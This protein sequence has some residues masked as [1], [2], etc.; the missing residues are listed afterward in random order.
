MGEGTPSPAK[1]VRRG[2]SLALFDTPCSSPHLDIAVE[3]LHHQ[4]QQ[5]QQQLFLAANQ[6][7]APLH[8]DG[9]TL[10]DFT[11][12]PPPSPNP[13]DVIGSF[14]QQHLALSATT[15]LTTSNVAGAGAAG[16]DGDGGTSAT[17]PAVLLIPTT[18]QGAPG[19]MNT[20]SG[21]VPIFSSRASMLTGTNAVGMTQQHQALLPIDTSPGGITANNNTAAID[22]MNP[23]YVE[24][25]AAHLMPL[26]SDIAAAVAAA[27]AAAATEPG[28]ILGDAQQHNCNGNDNS[29]QGLENNS[30]GIQIQPPARQDTGS[31]L[32]LEHIFDYGDALPHPQANAPGV[33]LPMLM[34]T[35]SNANVLRR[36]PSA[37]WGAFESITLAGGDKGEE[38]AKGKE[39]GGD[40]GRR[41]SNGSSFSNGRS[42]APSPPPEMLS[43]YSSPQA[44]FAAEEAKGG[45]EQGGGGGGSGGEEQQPSPAAVDV[46]PPATSPSSA[47]APGATAPRNASAESTSQAG[48]K[49]EHQQ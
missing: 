19:T 44:A 2:G 32:D 28:I 12:S 45:N 5:L 14:L 47:A 8:V 48:A 43:G 27:A 15:P 6:V 38:E 31:S 3:E 35:V 16:G 37:E 23:S 18:I 40:S 26:P 4:Q 41:P 34:S 33:M 39:E 29:Q 17:I 30:D 49:S 42:K 22:I 1:H 46:A 24:A 20:I 10:E 25:N 36:T 11:A 21:G 7:V 9:L 13:T